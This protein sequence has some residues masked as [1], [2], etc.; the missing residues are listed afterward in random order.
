MFD[1]VENADKHLIFTQTKRGIVGVFVGT[2]VYNTVHIQLRR[3]VGGISRTGN[4]RISHVEV[5]EL[6]DSILC[7][8]LRYRRISL[9]KPSEKL[10]DTIFLV[11]R[12]L[13]SNAC[14]LITRPG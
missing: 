2:V 14:H 11:S 12:Y 7:N 6:R 4:Y 8:K 10:G 5:V 13:L 9:R 1:I 3:L